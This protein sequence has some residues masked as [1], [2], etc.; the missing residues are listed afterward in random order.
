MW[1]SHYNTSVHRAAIITC[2]DGVFHGVRHDLSGPAVRELLEENGYEVTS[3]RVVA[4]ERP[5]ISAAIVEAIEA[6][7]QLVVTAGGTGIAPR[8]VTPEATMDVADRIIPGFG[9]LM[10]AESLLTTR[11][12]PLSRAQAA[13]RGSALVV[14]LPGSRNGAVENLKSVLGLIPHALE[15]LSG[16]PVQDHPRPR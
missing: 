5:L 7:A 16:V 13:T 4:D 15:L 10:R 3:L 9:E 2:S 6:G 11:M 8:D 1:N 12:A 14:N